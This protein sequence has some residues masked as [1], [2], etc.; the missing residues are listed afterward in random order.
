M[1]VAQGKE[2]DPGQARVVVGKDSLLVAVRVARVID[3]ARR[4]G[5]VGGIHAHAQRVLTIALDV[6]EATHAPL[7][8]SDPS[9]LGLIVRQVLTG[10]LDHEGTRGDEVGGAHRP[11]CV[12]CAEDLETHVHA[13]LHNSVGARGGARAELVALVDRLVGP[14]ERAR[15][16]EGGLGAHEAIAQAVAVD[17]W[18]CRA[19]LNLARARAPAP[20]G[21]SPLELVDG[22]H[23]R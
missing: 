15:G 11:T 6:H 20:R 14:D 8:I 16:A 3:K 12:G 23:A 18:T 19:P 17:A 10:I 13:P 7:V 4:I 1:N 22:E 9:L 2:G 21:L 5:E